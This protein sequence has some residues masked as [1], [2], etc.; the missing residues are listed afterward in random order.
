[1]F[2]TLFGGGGIFPNFR[3]FPP[4]LDCCE[5]IL[6]VTCYTQ[7]FAF[8]KLFFFETEMMM[9]ADDDNRMLKRAMK[10]LLPLFFC[11]AEFR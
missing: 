5:Y 11:S 8:V 2:Y 7:Y 1:M 9:T 6:T 4:V 3:K 10:L